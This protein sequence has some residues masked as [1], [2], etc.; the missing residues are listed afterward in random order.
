MRFLTF[1]EKYVALLVGLLTFVGKY[2]AL[3]VRFLTFVEKYVALLVGLLTFIEKYVALPA[4]CGGG[5]KGACNCLIIS[6]GASSATFFDIK[7]CAHAREA[8]PEH[9]KSLTCSNKS[10][11]FR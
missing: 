2:I 5:W 8:C 10:A 1:V 7:S 3:L 11:L 6:V 4:P 9:D